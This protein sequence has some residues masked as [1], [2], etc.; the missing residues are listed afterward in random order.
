MRKSAAGTRIERDF[1]PEKIANEKDFDV[2]SD[3]GP[4]TYFTRGVL[5]ARHRLVFTGMDNE[6]GIILGWLAAAVLLAELTRR[7]QRPLYFFILAIASFGGAVF[8]SFLHEEVVY[9][10]VSW[11]GGAGAVDSLPMKI[12]HETIS[13]IIL[14]FRPTGIIIGILGTAVLLVVRL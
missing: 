14:F 10:L 1:S 6:T 12:F 13:F 5:R 9:P 7:W 8:L 2:A 4:D 3:A 11:L